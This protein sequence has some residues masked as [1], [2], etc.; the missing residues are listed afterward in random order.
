MIGVLHILSEVLAGL[1]LALLLPAALAL[2]GG[3]PIG[4]NFLVVSGLVG[5]VAGAIFFALRGRQRALGRADRFV[6]VLV[7]WT[8]VPVI[9]ALPITLSTD[10]SFLAALFEAASG[11]TTTGA[12]VFPALADVG[13]AVIFWRAELQW[14]GGLAT[15]LTFVLILAPAELGGLSSRGWSLIGGF[16][17][18][19]RGRVREV[20]G[21]IAALY[22]AVTGACVVSLLVTGIPPLDAICL[23]FSTVSTGGFM[24]IDGT[25][26]AYG[27]LAVEFV[28]PAFMLIGATGITWQR[29]L[30]DRRRTLLAEERETYWVVGVALAAGVLYAVAF[31]GSEDLLTAIGDGLFAGVSL[32]STTG[33]ETRAAGLSALPD[34]LVL[35]LALGGAASL[36]TAGGLKVYRVG[37]MAVRASHELKRAIFPHAV[38]STRFGAQ[39]FDLQM[40]KAIWANLGLSLAVVIVAALLLSLALPGF[41]AALVAAVSAFSNVGPLYSPGWPLAA[42]WPPWAL[43]PDWSK[44]VV[45]LTMILGR[46]EVI[47]VFAALNLAYWRS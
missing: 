12:T 46:L 35:A 25:L 45:I 18:A 40:M 38:G 16:A 24:P 4:G 37:A 27:N 31:A 26:A 36:S 19:G 22:A 23:A 6:L 30:F 20:I 43:F 9:A 21:A 14:L 3:D 15:L 47:V 44:L 39:T 1:A 8:A 10:L 29:M 32:V 5:F 7:V 33:F 17:E 28:I 2:A 11:F 34:P 41:D 13:R 42:G